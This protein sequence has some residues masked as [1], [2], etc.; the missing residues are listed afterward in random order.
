MNEL[1][2]AGSECLYTVQYSG[3]VE[4]N[5]KLLSTLGLPLVEYSRKCTSTYYIQIQ[6]NNYR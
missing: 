3:T 2:N 4:L 5:D 1:V 6:N